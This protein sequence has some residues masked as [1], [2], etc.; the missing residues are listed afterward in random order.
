MTRLDLTP[1]EQ[2]AQ[3]VHAA[4]SFSDEHPE[5]AREWHHES[6]YLVV[7]AAPDEA[8]LDALL[9]RAGDRQ[10]PV[11]AIHEPDYDDALTAVVLAPTDEARRLCSSLP[12]ALREPAMV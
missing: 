3:S 11:T 7:V 5:I 10:I 9:Q 4:F 8:S 12:L 1:G 2:L 6:N